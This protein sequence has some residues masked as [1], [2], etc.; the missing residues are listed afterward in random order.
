[1]SVSDTPA[2][3]QASL[4]YASRTVGDT[5]AAAVAEC[6]SRATRA[7]VE[8]PQTAIG[9]LDL[10]GLYSWSQVQEWNAHVPDMLEACMHE[11]I[12]E[13]A[14]NFP[15]STA[16]EC[17]DG[18]ISYA[19]LSDYTSRLGSFLISRNVGPEVFVP[20]CF[21]KSLWAVVSMLGVMKAGG[22]FVCIDPAQPME[23]LRTIIEE[24]EAQIALSAPAYCDMTS[25]SVS[26]VIAV[27]TDFIHILPPC[28]DLPRRASPSNPAFAIFTSGSTGKPKGIV[29]EHRSMCT[30]AKEHA[31]RLNI[32][33]EVRTF[34]FAAY[35]FIVNTFELFT[36]LVVGGCVCVPSKEDRLGRTTGAMRDLGA[37][38]A[39]LTPSFLRSISPEEIPQVKTLVLAG[40]P[41]QQ[42][43]LDIWRSRVQMLNMYGAS[44]A[45][46]CITGDLS[47]PVDRS[48]IGTGTGCTTWVVDVANDDRLAPIGSIGELTVEGPVL[49]REY[50]HMPVKTASAFITGTPWLKG[51]RNSSPSRAYKTG[52]LVRYGSD[53]RINLVGR[54]DMQIKLRGQRIELEEVEFHMRQTL[55]RG[56]EV[57]IGLVKPSDQPDRPL[58]AAFAAHKKAF[59]DDF[60][61]ADPGAA[62]K[63]GSLTVNWKEQLTKAVPG[64]MVPSTLVKLNYMPLTASGKTNRK[65]IGE[66]GSML[67]ITELTGATKKEHKE[68]ATATGQVLRSLWAAALGTNEESISADDSFLQLGGSS[69]EAMKLVNL[70]RDENIGLSVADIFTYTQ[71]DKMAEASV[72]LQTQVFENIPFSLAPHQSEDDLEDLVEMA[73]SQC[74]ASKSAIEDLYPCTAMQEGLMALTDSREGAYIAHHTLSLGPK[75]NLAR[76]KQAC[77]EV[78]NAHPIL[79]TR[80]V[81]PEQYAAMQAVLRGNIDWHTNDTFE[82]YMEADKQRSMRAG[83]ALTRYGIVPKDNGWTFIWTVHHAVYDAWTLDLFFDR[84]DKAYKGQTPEPDHTFKEFMAF[85]VDTDTDAARQ[86]WT[87]YLAGA[88]RNE[89]PSAVS[90]SKQPM[91][92]TSLIR[93]VA[94]PATNTDNLSGITLPSM[95]RAAWGILI[96]SHSESDDV[97]FGGIVSGR[98]APVSNADKLF[99]PGI[100]AVPVRVRVPDNGALTI[101]EFLSNIQAESTK[102][103]S[104]EQTGLQHIS[105]V[106]PAAS[107]ACD[108]QTLLVVQPAKEQRPAPSDDSEDLRA[109]SDAGAE[110]GTYALTLECTLGSNGVRFAAHYDSSL[111][112][113][114]RVQRI[115]HQLDYLLQQICSS[116]AEKKVRDLDFLSAYDQSSIREWN[117]FIHPPV[118]HTVHELIEKQIAQKPDAEAV[119]AWDGSFTYDELDRHSARLT[120]RLRQLDA[121][122]E[123]YIPCCFEKGRWAPV[124]ML[125][126][127]QSGAAFFNVDP[128]QPASRIQL[129]IQK[130]KATTIVCSP[131]QYELCCQ[132][133]EG[134]NV[135]VFS[136]DSPEEAIPE[137]TTPATTGPENAVYAIFTSGSTGEPKG[138]IITHGAFAT[139]AVTHSPAMLM[140]G[141]ARALQFASWTFDAS[142]VETLT[143]M[144]VGGCICVP[145]EEQRKR[146]VTEAARATRA[147]WAALTPSFV[148][149]IKPDDM[150]DLK[151]LVLAGEAMSQAHV[152]TWGHRVRLING[153]GPSECCV[154]SVT[155]LDVKLGTSPRNIGLACSGVPWVVMPD[156]HTRLAPVGSVGELVLEGWNT[157]R[158]YLNEPEKTKAAFVDNPLWMDL[159]G[160]Q[161]PPVV[162]KTGDLVAYNV[163]GSLS[164]QRRK[165]TQVKLRGQRVEL[166]EIEYRIKQSLSD[167]P[168]AI[169]DILS[170]Q[171]APDQPRLVA[172]IP[173]PIGSVELD[174][175]DSDA[176][177]ASTV[178]KQHLAA[179]SGLEDHL[180][181]FLPMH[182]IPSA[183]VPVLT[184]PKQPSGKADRKTLKWCGSELTHRQMVEYSGA[185]GDAR[186]PT[187]EIQFALQQ[188]WAEALKTPAEQISLNDNFVR[189][190]GDSIV[191]M[192]L[193]S[194][195]R[196][197]GLPLSTANVFQHPTL[198]AMSAVAEEL[199]SQQQV[200]QRFVPFSTVRSIPKDE[201]LD[202]VVLPQVDVLPSEVQDVVES[203]DFQSLAVS[204]GLNQ[205]RGW[206]NYLV[207]DFDGPID[208]RRLEQACE[209]LLARHG[210][211]RTVFVAVP[212]SQNPLQVVLRSSTPEY[213]LHVQDDD[214]DPTEELVRYDL[215]RIPHLGDR[216]VRFMLIKN[217]ATKHRLIMRVSHAQY[218]GSSMP[219]L[220]Q[221]LRA[222][223]RGQKLKERPQFSDFVRM[224]LHSNQGARDFFSQ[225]L[226]GSN[227]T[228]IFRPS[229]EKSPTPKVMNTMIGEMIPLFAFRNYGITAATV[230]KAAW[231]LVLAEMAATPDVV[232]GHMVSGRNLPLDGVESVMGPCLNI[233]PVRVN[234]NTMGTILDLLQT[235]QQ[236]QT[237]TIPHESMGFRQIIDQCTDWPRG[238]RFSSVFQYQEFGGEDLAPGQHIP[239]EGVLKCAPGFICPAPD[240]CDLSILA[241]PVGQQNMLRVEMIF[242]NHAMSQD[243]AQ[244]AMKRLA[245]MVSVISRSAETPL[246]V[247]ELCAQRPVIPLSEP[248]MRNGTNGDV[249]GSFVQHMVNGVN[250]ING[251]VNGVHE[252][253]EQDHTVEKQ[254][255]LLASVSMN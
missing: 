26:Q 13:T 86:F 45:S 225:M 15:D 136:E 58:L 202:E 151:V 185:T 99:G 33:R 125:G 200:P 190:G 199:L 7:I 171:D 5:I 221:D 198:E 159:P 235:I 237:G 152:E 197:R 67:T 9:D 108:F 29:H 153:Y 207:F 182:M 217:G 164:F 50:L 168:D 149:L 206:N 140:D 101:P 39:C 156:D 161:R 254:I 89:F 22:A 132:M 241:T 66:L 76:F 71:L 96:G 131:E 92:D 147:N 148:S 21:D 219:L 139:G 163:D 165:D 222:A 87:R 48:T 40:E 119:S 110:F 228:S 43:N 243:F 3:V 35:T 144:T 60:Y 55:P 135:V 38:W 160:Q 97:V 242:S 231:A 123:T 51:I 188:L 175:E 251:D 63:L 37:N 94:L 90:M 248:K 16:L 100:A 229:S 129:M 150:P 19:E 226:A 2:G 115:L 11:M 189:L 18:S 124:A 253:P 204:G 34:Q 25:G 224:Q 227:M 246:S 65:A 83:D 220:M 212:G 158:G 62:E 157:G 238:T 191:A 116:P 245:R 30:S 24:V 82:H 6:V 162:Y 81:Y 120:R 104:F 250:G 106:S 79:R 213:T 196:T 174:R 44:E 233:V 176:I 240:A 170:P 32:N 216:I 68:P 78:V 143:V 195:A 193:A 17:W 20:V 91:A 42:D 186:P 27:D 80:I 187:T 214:E 154:A 75:I 230:I 107:A 56:V 74:Q 215:A 141:N 69:I 181:R 247:K 209:K 49:A 249:N 84:L 109:F 173:L 77:Q 121:Q 192:R 179:I 41:V 232:Y 178:P 177:I 126:I 166:G 117:Q 112:D 205:T 53:G 54:K 184:I 1:M 10:F 31:S 244:G 255:N 155:H 180:A 73:A 64:Y 133:G 98:N 194:A 167:H 47:Q 234:L 103:I 203:T 218:D 146:D 169:V 201:L 59:G 57:A 210:V 127:M 138:T 208:L 211:L 23:R 95:I 12:D 122:P 85:V 239:I 28:P 183:Y 172:F 142:I 114:D 70:A 52:D 145:S 4:L 128:G 14:K 130:L 93:H 236:Q 118:H 88:T 72:P 111:V 61:P 8:E 46:V 102:M 134:Y 137:P 105:R 223:Y 36:P 252:E 113:D